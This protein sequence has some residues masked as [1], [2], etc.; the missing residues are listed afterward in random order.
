MVGM[1][2]RGTESDSQALKDRLS[3]SQRKRSVG[4]G[5]RLYRAAGESVLGDAEL[6]GGAAG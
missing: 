6:C 2:A 1:E 5:H 4:R 3:V